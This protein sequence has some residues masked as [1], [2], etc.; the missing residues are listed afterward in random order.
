MQSWNP[1]S[2]REP[3]IPQQPQYPDQ[4]E[5]KSVEGQLKSAPPL[6]FAEETRS[7]FKQL[8]DVCEGRAFYF[9]VVIVLSRLVTSTRS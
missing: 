8:E 9:K 7:L 6:V 4:E 5:L 3:P 1:N 2:W